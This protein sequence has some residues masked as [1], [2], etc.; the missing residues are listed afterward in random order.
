MYLSLSIQRQVAASEHFHL[1]IGRTP[2]R[3]IALDHNVVP[4]KSGKGMAR[5]VSC[6]SLKWFS[7]STLFL[8]GLEPN[9]HCHHSWHHQWREDICKLPWMSQCLLRRRWEEH[10]LCRWHFCVCRLLVWWENAKENKT[11]DILPRDLLWYVNISVLS[12]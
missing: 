4:G 6:L 1:P 10:E 12:D 8:K 7:C 11:D 5:K 3:L 2:R 9:S